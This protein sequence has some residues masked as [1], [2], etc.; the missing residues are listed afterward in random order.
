MSSMKSKKGNKKCSLNKWFLVFS[1]TPNLF[2][3]TLENQMSHSNYKMRKGYHLLPAGFVLLM[4][5]KISQSIP[6]ISDLGNGCAFN[7]NS[8]RQGESKL[9]TVGNGCQP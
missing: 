1:F 6:D 8:N 7:S 4:S 2:F 9:C 3:N 5:L